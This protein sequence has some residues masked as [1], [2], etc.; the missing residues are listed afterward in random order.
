MM[1]ARILYVK[2]TR[3]SATRRIS[4]LNHGYV[5]DTVDTEKD[6]MVKMLDNHYDVVFV[7]LMMPKI[8]GVKLARIFKIMK[9]FVPVIMVSDLDEGMLRYCDH[10]GSIQR[11]CS[12]SQFTEA[13]ESH[14]NSEPETVP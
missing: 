4:S 5:V 2:Q 8:S 13:V 3:N 7:N 1:N 12:V 10:D 9:P 14:L 11:F 6:A